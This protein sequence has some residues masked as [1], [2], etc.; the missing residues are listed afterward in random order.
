MKNTDD[1]FDDREIDTATE[2]SKQSLISKLA[3][4]N[5]GSGNRASRNVEPLQRSCS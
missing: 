2:I 1:S 4:E 3:S 5:L